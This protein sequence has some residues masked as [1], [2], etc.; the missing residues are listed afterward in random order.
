MIASIKVSPLRITGV[1][2]LALLA[3]AGH[4]SAEKPDESNS[5]KGSIVAEH[6]QLRV[7]GHRIVGKSGKPVALHGMSLFW[8]QWMG[9]YYN[10]EA[11]KWLRDDW[12]CTVVRAAMAVESGGYLH[13][14]KRE[15]QKVIEV[16]DAA[17]DLGIYVIVDW[18]DHN[19]HQH[20]REAQEFFAELAKDYGR[21][22]NVI[23]E[24]WNEPL[25]KHDWSTVIKPYHEAVIPV[26]R[27]HDPDGL[28]VCGTQTW[29]QDVDKAARDPVKFGNVAYALHFYAATHKQSLRNKAAAALK[30]GL[31][32][33]V[34][35][36]GTSEASGNGKLDYEE[37]QRWLEFMD[38]HQLSWCNWSV[39]DKQETSAALRPRAS[40]KGGWRAEDLSRSGTLLR[41][42]LRVRSPIRGMRPMSATP[43]VPTR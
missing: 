34:T 22:P 33:M 37:T 38:R 13:N 3:A 23:Y 32:L 18:H 2:V 41:K 4:A 12:G 7:E 39:A 19:A 5:P 29:S 25:N 17:I 1:T 9:Q 35:E 30:G 15:K 11:V 20:T 16:I 42:E 26:I 10:A 28:I 21:Y 24:T 14:P 36:W 8:S 40:G 6:G 27:A 43:S 31:A